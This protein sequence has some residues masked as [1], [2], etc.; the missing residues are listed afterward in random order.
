MWQITFT[1]TQKKSLTNM[2]VWLKGQ[3]ADFRRCSRECPECEFAWIMTSLRL[4]RMSL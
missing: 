2:R 3:I 4:N 1:Q